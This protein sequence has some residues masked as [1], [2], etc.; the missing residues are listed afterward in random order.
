MENKLVFNILILFILFNNLFLK[1]LAQNVSQISSLNKQKVKPFSTD[2]PLNVV[3]Q[4]KIKSLVVSKHD[5]AKL[6]GLRSANKYLQ[7]VPSSFAILVNFGIDGRQR[8]LFSSNADEY[9]CGDKQIWDPFNRQCRQM[10]CST[11]FTLIGFKCVENKVIEDTNPTEPNVSFL[12]SNSDSVNITLGFKILKPISDIPQW[13][14]AQNVSFQ[15]E[16]ITQFTESFKI[17]PE[18]SQSIANVTYSVTQYPNILFVN[19]ILKEDNKSDTKTNNDTILVLLSSSV[20]QRGI[21]FNLFDNTV[22]A[23]SIHSSISEMKS[24]CNKLT[25]IPIWYTNSQFYLQTEDK[26]TYLYV[27][28]TGR[29]Y[30]PGQYLGNVLYVQN[31]E[32]SDDSDSNRMNVS[33]SAVVCETQTLIDQ[34]C[35]RILLNRSEYKW[36]ESVDQKNVSLVEI[37][38]NETHNRFELAPNGVFVCIE[39]KNRCLKIQESF[40]DL[41]EDILSTVLIIISIISLTCVL[42]TYLTFD[43]L[44]STINGFNTINLSLCI[45]VM[46][47]LFLTNAY[48]FECKLGAK[49][50]H[51]LLLLTISWSR[52]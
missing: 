20:S 10:Y 22:N 8:M 1:I 37:R 2:L 40:Q 43:S 5:H 26:V 19:F 12:D 17:L 6:L 48:I 3:P 28:Q 7:S 36:I 18:M 33:S 45:E 50:L 27:N 29:R 35:P 52:Y 15:T 34:S 23:V 42:I 49:I 16:F 14:E 32:M 11:H 31:M 4:R 46:Q 39:A 38:S 44:R 30:R 21:T 51:F 24:F 13:I 25:E 9:E 47:I 41:V